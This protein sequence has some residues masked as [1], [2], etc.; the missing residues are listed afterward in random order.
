MEVFDWIVKALGAVGGLIGTVLGVYNY[1]HARRKEKREQEEKESIQKEQEEEW[2]LYAGL[3]KA[4]EEGLVYQPKIGSIEHKRAERL[5]EK[6]MLERLPLAG[7][8]Y[9]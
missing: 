9:G 2:K 3:V 7:G 5:V 4:S 6:G 1:T 8:Y